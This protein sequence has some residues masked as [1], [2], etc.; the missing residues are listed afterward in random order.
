MQFFIAEVDDGYTVLELSEE[1]DPADI[2]AEA[3]GTVADAGP[4]AAYDEANDAIT[5]LEEDTY[6]ANRSM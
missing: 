6:A 2:A 5:E 4:F 3:G 1:V